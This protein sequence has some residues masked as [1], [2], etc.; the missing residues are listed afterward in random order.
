MPNEPSPSP[1]A[2]VPAT[3]PVRSGPLR[4]L[5]VRGYRLARALLATGMLLLIVLVVTPIPDRIFQ[6]LSVSEP[7][8]KADAIVCLGGRYERLVWTADLFNRGFAPRVIVSN[9][10][11]A[12]QYMKK[13]LTRCGVPAQNIIVDANSYTTADH[14]AAVGALPGIDPKVQRVLIVTDHEH[15]RRVAG[16]FRRGGYSHFSIHS[17]PNPFRDT[18]ESP[19]RWRRRIIYLPRIAYECAGLLQYWVQGKI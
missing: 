3:P 5:I 18:Q 16:C 1:P 2:P 7:P 4:R 9:A 15:S 11:G 10:P 12:S 6:W 17:G 8:V 13:L 19:N 14:P